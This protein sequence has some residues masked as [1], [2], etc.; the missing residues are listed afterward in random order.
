MLTTKKIVTVSWILGGLSMAGV[1]I[2]HAYASA[3]MD[4]TRDA[5]GGVTCVSK[6]EKN[7]TTADGSYHL[8]QSQECTHD[9]R[10]V[11]NT[12]QTGTGLPGT[13]KIG[14]VVGC[15]NTA[16]APEGFTAPDISR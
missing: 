11:V 14:P 3:P 16:P 8:E 5:Q 6:T 15:S 12:P 10:D 13:T 7:Y 1:G 2:G 4:C 9:G